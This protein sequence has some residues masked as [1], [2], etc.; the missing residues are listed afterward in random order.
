M[1]GPF[2][3]SEIINLKKNEYLFKQGYTADCMYIVK[4]GQISLLISDE[5]TEKE[6]D[7]ASPGQLLGEMSLFD[8]QQRSASA[9]ALTDAV[10]L[11]LPY[12]KLMLELQS[13][14]PW[15]QTVLKKL[16][17]K[18]RE[19]NSKILKAKSS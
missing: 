4:S 8:N 13:M 14:P 10:L 5:L 19:T 16:S 2:K 1:D 6:I 11:K 9:L 12:E 7:V 3:L 17:E 18:L 15:V